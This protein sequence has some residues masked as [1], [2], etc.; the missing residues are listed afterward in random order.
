[1]SKENKLRKTLKYC[2]LH[3]GLEGKT[4]QTEDGKKYTVL[5]I[6]LSSSSEVSITITFEDSKVDSR[7]DSSEQINRPIL[8]C[9]GDICIKDNLELPPNNFPDYI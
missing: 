9:L 4:F 2:I 1:M 7:Y 3:A 8:S 6:N 5:D